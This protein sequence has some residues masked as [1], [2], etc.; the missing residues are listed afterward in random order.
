MESLKKNR[1]AL[2]ASV[3]QGA[4]AV[5]FEDNVLWVWFPEDSDFHA[6][7]ARKARHVGSL[8]DAVEEVSG[9]RPTEV[10]CMVRADS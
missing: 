7:E 1:Q 4:D 3:F 10:H 6:V 2:T 5:L 8:Q 9:S